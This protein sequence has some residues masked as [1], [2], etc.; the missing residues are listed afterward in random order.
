MSEETI[1]AAIINQISDLRLWYSPKKTPWDNLS[2]DEAAEM[3]EQWVTALTPFGVA[4][5][6]DAVEAWR[7]LSDWFPSLNDFVKIC[8]DIDERRR[9]AKALR[10][11]VSSITHCD[12]SGWIPNEADAE[13][14]PRCNPFVRR[15]FN[16]KAAWRRFRSGTPMYLL[17]SDVKFVNGRLAAPDGE[18]MPAPCGQAED[19]TEWTPFPKGVEIARR[20]YVAEAAANNREINMKLFDATIGATRGL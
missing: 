13:P 6:M 18:P 3:S 12:G 20:A 10:M 9:M 14:C 19:P 15:L 7:G 8:A 5:V 1:I 4:T 17:L 16:D 2:T 11:P